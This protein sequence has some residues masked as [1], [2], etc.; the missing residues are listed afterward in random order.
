MIV[1]KHLRSGGWLRSI[2]PSASPSEVRTF[3]VGSSLAVLPAL[4][5]HGRQGD[6]I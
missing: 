6:N 3:D 1:E 5:F 2:E 4:G